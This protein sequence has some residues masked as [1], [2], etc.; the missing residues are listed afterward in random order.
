MGILPGLENQFN[1]NVVFE[2]TEF[3]PVK[4]DCIYVFMEKYKYQYFSVEKQECLIW[5]YVMQLKSGQYLHCSN[6]K[7]VAL[8]ET[9]SLGQKNTEDEIATSASKL[10]TIYVHREPSNQSLHM[11]SYKVCATDCSCV[12]HC[13]K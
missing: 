6:N 13:I 12:K 3:K 4:F 5:S 10:S 1:P 8:Y 9:V 11:S 2:P 7:R